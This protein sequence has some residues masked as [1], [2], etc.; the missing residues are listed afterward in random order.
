MTD[1]GLASDEVAAAIALQ[2]MPAD[3]THFNN[4]L[5]VCFSQDA[6]A[7]VCPFFVLVNELLFLSLDIL[8]R[9]QFL[10][11]DCY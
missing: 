5:V 3:F 10:L 2:V 1:E 8:F 4:D 11:H 7:T 6:W 9:K